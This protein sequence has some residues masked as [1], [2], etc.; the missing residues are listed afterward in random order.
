MTTNFIDLQLDK[1]TGDLIFTDGDLVLI[2]TNLDS[3]YPW[4]SAFG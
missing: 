4:V 1:E 2:Q 3:V